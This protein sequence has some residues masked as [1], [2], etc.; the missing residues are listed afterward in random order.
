MRGGQIGEPQ[1]VEPM[2]ATLRRLSTAALL[3]LAAAPLAAQGRDTIPLPEQPR[4]DFARAEWLNLNG[5]WRFRFD[6]ADGGERAR[7]YATPMSAARTILVPFSWGAPLSGVPDSADIG[8]YE[9]TITVPRAWAGK[10]VYLVVGASDWRTSLWLDGAKL[11]DHQGGYTPF[12][13]ELT[14]RARPGATPCSCCWSRPCCCRSR[15][16]WCRSS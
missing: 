14:K 16:R 10:R 1:P 12:A 5:H 2:R 13:V 7:W 9:R 15:S 3:A 8:W 4:P 6:R 11:G